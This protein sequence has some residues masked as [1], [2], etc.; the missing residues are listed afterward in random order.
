MKART[1]E[2]VQQNSEVGAE[3][4]RYS[5][6][7]YPMV[8]EVMRDRIYPPRRSSRVCSRDMADTGANAGANSAHESTS[9]CLGQFALLRRV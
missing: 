2:R 4:R 3:E 9:G 5:E 7:P 8:Q 6:T 1:V